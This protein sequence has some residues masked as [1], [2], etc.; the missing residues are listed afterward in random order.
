MGSASS[1]RS[2]RKQ[3]T[4]HKANTLEAEIRDLRAELR[5]FGHEI[6]K[7]KEMITG[8]DELISKLSA[9]IKSVQSQREKELLAISKKITAANTCYGWYCSQIVYIGEGLC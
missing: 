2:V 9:E 7:T 3:S 8:N 6:G 1:A 5:T 4:S